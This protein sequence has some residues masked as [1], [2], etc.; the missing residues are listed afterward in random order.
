VICQVL[1]RQ[2]LADALSQEGLTSAHKL[3]GYF[4]DPIELGYSSSPYLQLKRH[5]MTI[6]LEL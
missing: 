3:V 1:V 6:E 5:P 2:E 4:E